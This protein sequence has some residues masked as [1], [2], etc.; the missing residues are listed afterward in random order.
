LDQRTIAVISLIGMGLDFLGGLY[1]ANDL[2]GERKGILR[3][4]LRWA[5]YGG[6][7]GLTYAALLGRVLGV[8]AGLG[9]GMALALELGS[10]K[11][12]QSLAGWVAHRIIFAM[13]RA[14]TLAVGF[15]LTFTIRFGYVFFPA[16]TIALLATYLIGFSPAAMQKS[17]KPV[18]TSQKFA[19]ALVRAVFLGAAASL[20]A[21][22]SH[23]VGVPLAFAA[24]IGT[25][26]ALVGLLV[27]VLSPIIETAT[28]SVPPSA[29][30]TSAR[31]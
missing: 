15:G 30:H 31:S 29:W 24:R 28:D 25:A 21:A 27:G 12:N 5:L 2:F 10:A 7:F 13:L 19:G 11:G 16:G 22:V 14:F 1:L 4:L 3:F 20:A 26:V 8:S 9:L 17:K 6:I 18:L 23:S